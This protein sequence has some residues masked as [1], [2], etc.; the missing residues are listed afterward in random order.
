MIEDL[1]K[2]LIKDVINEE[3]IVEVLKVEEND[4]FFYGINIMIDVC[5]GW[6][7]NVV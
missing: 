5:Y 4:V 6:R 7:R 1:V 2:E 3:V